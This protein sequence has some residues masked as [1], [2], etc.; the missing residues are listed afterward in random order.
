MAGIARPIKRLARE[1]DVEEEL[2]RRSRSTSIGVRDRAA[3]IL[4]R[5]QGGRCRHRRGAAEHNGKAG[6]GCTT[7]SDGLNRVAHA[8][9]AGGGAEMAFGAAARPLQD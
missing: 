5:L 6:F 7:P 8:L 2:R 3:I 4:L 9:G 1:P